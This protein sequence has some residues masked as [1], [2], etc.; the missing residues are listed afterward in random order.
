MVVRY[1]GGDG[2]GASHTFRR[3]PRRRLELRTAVNPDRNFYS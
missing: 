1:G 2:S 3:D